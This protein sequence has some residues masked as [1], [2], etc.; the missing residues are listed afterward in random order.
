MIASFANFNSFVLIQLLTNGG[1]DRLGTTTPAGYTDLLVAT[2]T[3]ISRA[4]AVRTS[5]WRR[6]HCHADLPAGRRAGNSE[7]EKPRV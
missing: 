4:A 5:V 6:P 7:P 2:P 3:A 1:P